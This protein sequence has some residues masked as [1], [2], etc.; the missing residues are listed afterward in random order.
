M[1]RRRPGGFFKISFVGFLLGHKDIVELLIENGVNTSQKNN[2]GL[3]GLHC[4]AI[5][6][7][8]NIAR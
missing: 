2:Q 6:G 3:S 8:L 7:D 1:L 5:K 4:A